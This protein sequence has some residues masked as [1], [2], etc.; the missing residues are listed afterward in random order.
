MRKNVSHN[1]ISFCYFDRTG[2]TRRRTFIVYIVSRHGHRFDSTPT[3]DV[4][5]FDVRNIDT[6][7][8]STDGEL[9]STRYGSRS[10]CIGGRSSDVDYI[11]STGDCDVYRR[12][13]N[14][15]AAR[16]TDLESIDDRR[17]G[18]T[19]NPKFSQS[20]HF[21]KLE[22][23]DSVS[24]VRSTVCEKRSRGS[25]RNVRGTRYDTGTGFN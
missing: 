16:Q 25:R 18:S 14:T 6:D 17:R 8:R 19:A 10:S 5:P 23:D 24:V 15:A 2:P 20:S 22:P 11:Y 7:V 4:D 3:N 12:D 13:G 21:V 9:A 1:C